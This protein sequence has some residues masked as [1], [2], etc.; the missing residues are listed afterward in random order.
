MVC[1]VKTRRPPGNSRA[2]YP[3][4]AWQFLASLG[5]LT[6]PQWIRVTLFVVLVG[7]TWLAAPGIRSTVIGLIHCVV[8]P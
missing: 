5:T 3:M 2:T 7:L 4:T 6:W 1:C 8:A